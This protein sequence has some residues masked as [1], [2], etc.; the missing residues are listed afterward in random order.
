MKRGGFNVVLWDGSVRFVRDSVNDRTLS[1]LV[2]P[3]DGQTIP[4]DW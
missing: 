1:L 4:G 2:N 3:A